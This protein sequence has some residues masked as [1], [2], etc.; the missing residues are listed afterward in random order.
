[1]SLLITKRKEAD[2]N[3]ANFLFFRGWWAVGGTREFSGG[4]CESYRKDNQKFSHFGVRIIYY[5]LPR[6]EYGLRLRSL[7]CEGV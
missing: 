2:R 3:W 6:M 4:T 5:K 7:S 1:M